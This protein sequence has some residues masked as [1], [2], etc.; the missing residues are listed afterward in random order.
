[1]HEREVLGNG[2]SPLIDLFPSRAVL[3]LDIRRH[4]HE[5]LGSRTGAV[6]RRRRRQC[7]DTVKDDPQCFVRHISLLRT[8]D[9]EPGANQAKRSP[10]TK[11]NTVAQQGELRLTERLRGSVAA[12]QALMER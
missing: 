5:R 9:S 6:P 8:S 3:F 12:E 4:H 7:G 1:M 10:I 2:R 11:W